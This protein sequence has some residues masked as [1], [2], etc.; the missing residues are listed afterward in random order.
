MLAGVRVVDLTTVVMGPWATHVLAAYGAD[1]VKVEPPEGDIMRYASAARHPGMGAIYLHGNRGKRSVV[2]D[3][4]HAAG[5]DALLR[6]CSRADVFV[7]NVRRG[8]ME[9]LGL[10]YSTLAAVAPELVYVTLSGFGRDGPY[11]D[12]PAYDDLIQGASGLAQ[13]FE[14]AGESRPRYVPALIGDRIGGMAAV[15][16]ILAALYA[17]ERTG[18]GGNIDVPMFETLVELVLS[19][20]LGGETFEPPHGPAGYARALAANRRPYATADG[21]VCLLLYTEAHWE[22][23]FE[24]VGRRS[25]YRADPRLCE[26]AVRAAH[27]D[28]AYGAVAAVLATRP[29]AHWLAALAAADLPVMPLGDVATLA[30]DPHLAASGFIA[31]ENHPSEG[32]IRTLGMPVRHDGFPSPALRPAPRLGE[33][34]REVLREAGYGDAEID[35]LIAGGTTTQANGPSR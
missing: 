10:G 19:D 28:E 31:I 32:P 34:S 4:K 20:H 24:L 5:R 30:G 16:A 33:H 23:F 21:Y 3:L 27:F 11:A 26:R 13:L 2:L 8:A 25:E 29:T 17:R 18:R 15:S 35:G 1:V 14:R 7:H 12:R 22:R 9:R 6:L